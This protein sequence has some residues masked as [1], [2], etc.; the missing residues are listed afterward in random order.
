MVNPDIAIPYGLILNELVSNC[1][2]HAF[3]PG[4]NGEVQIE[5]RRRSTVQATLSVRDNG[6]GFPAEVDFRSAESL[7]LQLI[8]ALVEQLR[9]TLTL[10]PHAGTSFTLWFTTPTFGE[11]A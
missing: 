10:D 1:L 9:G 4:G 3:P 8:T 11:S 6:R 2:K 5:L 7:G